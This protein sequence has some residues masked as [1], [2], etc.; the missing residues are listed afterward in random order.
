MKDINDSRNEINKIDEE[1]AKL[2]CKRMSICKEIAEYKK[3][4]SMPILDAN[5]E[6]AVIENN[7]KYIKDEELKP[8]YT[9]Y[10]KK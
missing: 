7:L 1:M 3:E 9:N 8:Y 4:N 6:M 2:F 10:I 5:R